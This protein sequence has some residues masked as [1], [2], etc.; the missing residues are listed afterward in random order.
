MTEML[1]LFLPS[2]LCVHP[3]GTVAIPLCSRHLLKPLPSGSLPSLATKPSSVSTSTGGETAERIRFTRR[4]HVPASPAHAQAAQEQAHGSAG[5]QL[6]SRCPAR[7]VAVWHGVGS[8]WRGPVVSSDAQSCR[9]V[10]TSDLKATYAP[11]KH[12]N[13]D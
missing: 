12:G 6:E 13:K 5:G 8:S 7:G 10:L 4:R 3:Y 9:R 11:A 2:F 1:T